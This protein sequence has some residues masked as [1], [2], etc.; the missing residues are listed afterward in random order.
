ML[1]KTL[2][3]SV[4]FISITCFLCS[5]A[6]AQWKIQYDADA[7]KVMHMGG[8]TLRG[9]FATEQAC[10]NYWASRTAYERNHSKCV[11]V[12]GGNVPTGGSGNISQD[13]V[14]QFF[15]SMLQNIFNPPQQTPV[16]AAAQQRAIE[17][18]KLQNQN[19]WQDYQVKQKVK[20]QAQ[21]AAKKRQGEELFS[22]M[23]TFG[24]GNSLG[25]EL[26]GS[27]ELKTGSDD[28]L[29]M[30]SMSS[31][32]YDTASLSPLNRMR[33]ANYFSQKALEA[34]NNGDDASA[35]YFSLQAQKVMAGEM[36]DE[37]YDLSSL[38]DVPEPP[39]PTRV[40]EQR[41]GF[42]DYN[43][44]LKNDIKIKLKRVNKTQKQIKK[45]K[46]KA[47]QDIAKFKDKSK[48]TKS[49]Q[50]KQ[51]YD[52]L[53]A[54]AKQLLEESNNNLKEIDKIKKQFKKQQKRLNN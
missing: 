25:S 52:E 35:R 28:I 26:F 14:G 36:V 53:V 29:Q 38:P 20:Q 4:M 19:Q 43:A 23:S 13:I 7:N 5:S 27:K 41:Q 50:E 2:F 51:E 17:A 3:C 30:Q 6:Y 8:D 37:Q 46:K 54:K 10:R 1:K 31:G 12:G 32:K 24:S 49:A 9:N 15:G 42:S 16:D 48:K 44:Y 21:E 34:M 33:A 39:A 40:N 18:Q 22:Q 11:Y 47:E 45:Q